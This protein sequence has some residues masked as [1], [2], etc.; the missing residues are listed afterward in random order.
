[1]RFLT[2]FVT[3][4]A[5]LMTT[6]LIGCG[7][8]DPVDTA[9]E[10]TGDG[11]GDG[12]ANTETGDPG[13]E[14][15]DCELG[16]IGDACDD[17]CGCA[18]GLTCDAGICSLGGDGDGDGDGDPGGECNTYDPNMCAPPGALLMVAD[19][20]GNFCSCPCATNED[21]PMGP[22]GTTPGCVLGMMGGM[23]PNLCGLICTPAMGMMDDDCPEGSTCKEVPSQPG[24]GLCT[25]P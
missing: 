7:E 16:M 13:T 4:A 14:T 11:D 15:G 2:S 12:D 21:C 19:V 6:G 23:T 3:G 1:M 10:T 25:Y 9:A 22:A 18:D 8:P 5:L 20:E 24:V 17:A